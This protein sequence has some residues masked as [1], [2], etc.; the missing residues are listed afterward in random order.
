MKK[1]PIF[2]QT[3]KGEKPVKTFLSS[4][5]ESIRAKIVAR[6]EFLGEHWQELRRPYVDT[7]DGELYELRVQFGKNKI[8]VIYAYMFEDYI[9]LLHSFLKT[10]KEIPENDKLIAK[11]RMYD[12]QIQYNEGRIKLRKIN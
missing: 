1:I 8:R 9:V 3:S 7:I 2:Y 11:K 6:I 12:F 10:T 4:I 5:E